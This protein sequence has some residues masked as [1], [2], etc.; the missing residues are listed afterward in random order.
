MDWRE[1]QPTEVTCQLF[2][3]QKIA[4]KIQRC[5]RRQ[6]QTDSFVALLSGKLIFKTLNNNF[7]AI[8]LCILCTL[9]SYFLCQHFFCSF[10]FFELSFPSSSCLFFVIFFTVLTLKSLQCELN[11]TSIY[12]AT[13]TIRKKKH[14]FFFYH[15]FQSKPLIASNGIFGGILDPTTLCSLILKFCLCTLPVLIQK[16]S[17]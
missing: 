6:V 16:N 15:S 12:K 10:F 7:L 13:L 3:R 17:R 8:L 4:A 14:S 11:A 9:S 2:A 5:M 1:S